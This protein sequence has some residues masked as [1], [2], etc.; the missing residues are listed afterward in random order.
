MLC[1]IL[2]ISIARKKFQPIIFT[3]SF[4]LLYIVKACFKA[5]SSPNMPKKIV[6][7][8]EKSSLPAARKSSKRHYSISG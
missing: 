8:I 7:F 5:G 2:N 4:Q 3:Y 1:F 6:N